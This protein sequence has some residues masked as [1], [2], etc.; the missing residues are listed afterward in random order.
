MRILLI[1]ALI[2]GFLGCASING[3]VGTCL[4]PNGQTKAKLDEW[5]ADPNYAP[6]AVFV[7][8][9]LIGVC[10]EENSAPEAE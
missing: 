1:T 3:E 7:R 2:I 10:E 5:A 8:D 6:F 4:N 9:T